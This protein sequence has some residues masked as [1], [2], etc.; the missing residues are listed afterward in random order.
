[1]KY[2]LVHQ[3]YIPGGKMREVTLENGIKVW[4]FSSLQYVQATVQNIE[5]YLKEKV[6]KFPPRAGTP[7]GSSHRPELDFTPKL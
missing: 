4:L 2:K 3:I 7:L 6:K 1:M 5:K